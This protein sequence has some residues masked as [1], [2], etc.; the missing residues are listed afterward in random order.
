[1]PY[2]KILL[3]QYKQGNLLQLFNIK[4]IVLGYEIF[5][6]APQLLTLFLL[7]G[8]SIFSIIWTPVTRNFLLSLITRFRLS[9]VL[10]QIL[11]ITAVKY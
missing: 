1:M 6:S 9:R 3:V 2:E 4:S 7:D 8:W 10:L 5:K 11:K